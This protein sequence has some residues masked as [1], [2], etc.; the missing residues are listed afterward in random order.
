MRSRLLNSQANDGAT[1]SC[2]TA[3]VGQ[4][5]GEECQIGFSAATAVTATCLRQAL[6]LTIG[7]GL[8]R[9]FSEDSL[10]LL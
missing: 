1:D 3:T 9:V 5:P 2:S 8:W 4:G 10:P 7:E 6:A